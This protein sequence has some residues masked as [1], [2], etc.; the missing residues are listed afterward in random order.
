MRHTTKANVATQATKALL[1]SRIAAVRAV[2]GTSPAAHHINPGIIVGQHAVIVKDLTIGKGQI[3]QISY[4]RA[5]RVADHLAVA[6]QPE[7]A[8]IHVVLALF[9]AFHQ[10]E[11]RV[12]SLSHTGRINGFAGD[13]VCRAQ[14]SVG[15][16]RKD[17]DTRMMLFQD[18]GIPI[19][20]RMLMG[21][22]RKPHQIR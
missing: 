20:E 17:E 9:Q 3:V 14:G 15:P 21:G 16:S 5:Q 1:Q 6:P 12:F 4:Q 2:V 13:Y 7:V 22:R 19:D 8:H 18:S 10:F 11:D